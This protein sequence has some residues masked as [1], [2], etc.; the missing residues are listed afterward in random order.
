MRLDSVIFHIGLDKFF[1]PPYEFYELPS[2]AFHIEVN[3]VAY[4]FWV[5]V[6]N[7]NL[8]TTI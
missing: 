1:Y 2:Y 8:Y 6:K 5:S 3:I 4:I 7:Q